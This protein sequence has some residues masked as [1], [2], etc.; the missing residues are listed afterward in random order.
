MGILGSLPNSIEVSNEMQICLV[1]EK[2]K[3]L[4]EKQVLENFLVFKL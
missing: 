4:F 1:V 2:S 3:Y